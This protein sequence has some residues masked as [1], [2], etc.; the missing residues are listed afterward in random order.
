MLRKVHPTI[1]LSKIPTYEELVNFIETD[2][3]KIKLPNRLAYFRRSHPFM[4]QDDGPRFAAQKRQMDHMMGPINSPYQPERSDV[5]MDPPSEDFYDPTMDVQDM[6]ARAYNPPVSLNPVPDVD[7]GG[8]GLEGFSTPE[9]PEERQMPIMGP[10][11]PTLL[12]RATSRIADSASSGVLNAVSQYSQDTAAAALGWMGRNALDTFQEYQ[13]LVGGVQTTPWA[14]LPAPY[15]AVNGGNGLILTPGRPLLGDFGTYRG[16]AAAAAVPGRRAIRDAAQLA[17][18][19]GGQLALADAPQ[20]IGAAGEAA[21]VGA[22]LFEGA[23][24]GALAGTELG[25]LG[26][27]AGGLAGA[28]IAGGGLLFGGS[29]FHDTERPRSAQTFAMESMSHAG[30]MQ[31]QPF[32]DFNTLNGMNHQTP[33]DRGGGFPRVMRPTLTRPSNAIRFNIGSPAPGARNGSIDP[34]T[35]GGLEPS[36]NSLRAQA[37][38][39]ARPTA[40]PPA[41]PT[42]SSRSRSGTNIPVPRSGTPSQARP[43]PSVAGARAKSRAAPLTRGR[44]STVVPT[45]VGARSKSRAAPVNRASSSYD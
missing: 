5:N 12:Q 40:R 1:G 38:P 17:L 6:F 28:A 42:A 16:E 20:V 44:P 14:S 21:T 41:R 7:R 36:Y 3:T 27:L 18:E 22:G 31:G 29:L 23:E 15:A 11:E 10:A 30:G 24:V 37:R 32:Q 43:T 39:T 33:T 26:M 19:N 13:A 45:V 34:V 8:L 35:Q 4:T 9:M 2:E 25:P